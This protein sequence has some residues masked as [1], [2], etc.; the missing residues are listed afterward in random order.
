MKQ[1]KF[2][3]SKNKSQTMQHIEKLSEKLQGSE[4]ADEKLSTVEE[5]IEH[6]IIFMSV[7]RIQV[8]LFTAILTMNF[9]KRRVT[10]DHL[11]GYF[12]CTGIQIMKLLPD[13]QELQKKR[14]IRSD[15]DGQ[16]KRSM[17]TDIN[18]YVVRDV[19]DRIMSSDNKTNV[20]PKK[21]DIFKFLSELMDLADDYD[22]E[23]SSY[24]EMWDDARELIA[25]HETLPFMKILKTQGLNESEKLMF[26]LM[27]QRTLIGDGE[28]DLDRLV[29][30]VSETT[31]NGIHLKRTIIRKTSKLVIRELIKLQEGMFHNDYEVVVTDHAIQLFFPDDMDILIKKTVNTS[32]LVK[33]EN[34]KP[35]RLFFNN[36]ENESLKRLT[37]LLTKTGYNGVVR[38]LKAHDMRSGF[39]VLLHGAPGTGKTEAVNQLALRTG[40]QVM[41]VDLSKAKSKWFGESEKKITEIFAQYRQQL[42]ISKNAHPILLF[43]EADG[44]F[45]TRGAT[46]NSPSTT[47]QTFNT[48]QNILLEE[49]ENFEGILI[50]TTNLTKN[51][52]NAFERRFLYKI[53]FSKPDE[54]TRRKIWKSKIQKL[55]PALANTLSSEFD[56]SGGQIENITRKFMI[57]S[58][59]NEVSASYDTLAAYCREE[60]IHKTVESRLGY[61]QGIHNRAS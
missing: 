19:F 49:M 48:M 55:T 31:Y 33:S 25:M 61:R 59:L 42:K 24:S 37:K 2:T 43:N 29:G 6:L 52:D 46:E 28:V 10:I 40:R 7:T 4:F 60:L 17:L 26:M 41:R 53:E 9:K 51:F 1:S 54:Q 38:R 16:N 36:T 11:S 30:I 58:V 47:T 57:D 18:Y 39:T 56:F 32:N 35:V 22:R 44:I 50:A 15:A 45:G 12:K 5:S 34:I 21:K 8:M 13:L 3:E 27:C 23:R 14:W 20:K